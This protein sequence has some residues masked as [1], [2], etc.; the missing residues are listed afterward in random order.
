MSKVEAISYAKARQTAQTAVFRCMAN[1]KELD[2]KVAEL[3]SRVEYDV[4]TAVDEEGKAIYSNETKRK[5][6]AARILRGNTTYRRVQRIRR[7]LED[8]IGQHK[9]D[10]R[11]WTDMV[12]IE[13]AFAAVH[14]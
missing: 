3:E 4:A 6:E 10:E 1:L 7:D 5:A 11:Y 14:D 8:E 9:A 12:Q 13:C 2:L